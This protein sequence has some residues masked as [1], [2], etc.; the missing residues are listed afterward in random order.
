MDDDWDR[1]LVNTAFSNKDVKSLDNVPDKTNNF[2]L[3]FCAKKL[4]TSSTSTQKI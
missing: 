1:V 4:H 3:F 2:F